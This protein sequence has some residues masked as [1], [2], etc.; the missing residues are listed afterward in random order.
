MTCVY[1]QLDLTDDE[2]EALERDREAVSALAERLA[3]T[4]TPADPT[5]S[6][7]GTSTAFI[8]LTRLTNTITPTSGDPP[9]TD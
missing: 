6:E 1:E 8:L 3:D 5:P 2:R 9:A 7:L 4:P